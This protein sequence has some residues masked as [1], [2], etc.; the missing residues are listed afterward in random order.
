MIVCEVCIVRLLSKFSPI[1][2][3]SVRNFCNQYS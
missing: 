2:I 1:R 3:C